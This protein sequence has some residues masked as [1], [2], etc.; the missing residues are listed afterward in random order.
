MKVK[1][2]LPAS[3]L[4][5]FLSIPTL[6]FGQYFERNKVQYRTFDFFVK[7]TDH[8][9]VHH[10]PR[11]AEAALDSALMLERWYERHAE[12]L[13][14]GLEDRQK[15]ILYNNFVDFEQT[16]A[17]S[18][19]IPPEEGGITESLDRRIIVPLT[20]I[21]AENFHVLGHELVHAF[22]ME[23][24]TAPSETGA[25]LQRQ[26]TWFVEGQAEYLSLGPDDPLTS[27]WMRDAV[28]NVNIPSIDDLSWRPD[29]FFPYRFGHAVWAWIDRTWGKEGVRSFFGAAMSKGIATAVDS[30]LHEK[31]LDEFSRKWK[32]DLLKTT[33]PQLAG[34]TLP[35]NAGRTLPGIGRGTNLSPV[36]SPDGEYIA[37]FSRRDTF[38]FALYLA[39]A[40]N[41]RV[42][43]TLAGSENDA[44][45]DALRFIDSAGTWSPDSRSFA[46]TVEKDGSDAVA[47]ADVPGGVVRKVLR[48]KDVAGVS[49]LAWSPDGGHIALSGTRDGIRDLYLLDPDTGSLEQLTD[50]WHAEIQPA[51]SPNSRTLAFAVDRGAKTDKAGLSFGSMNIGFMDMATRQ[52]RIVSLKDG[53]KHINP[54]F[55]PDG[56]ALYFVSDP[57][58]F[59]D[60][61]RYDLDSEEFLRVT[62][63]A[64]G[65]SGL[66]RLSPCLSVTRSTGELVFLLFSRGSYEVHALSAEQSRGIPVAFEG[67]I[68]AQALAGEG[69]GAGGGSGGGPG[70][71][72]VG[73]GGGGGSGGGCG[74][75]NHG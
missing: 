33:M 50:D 1:E 40:A 19:L 5:F 11:S 31:S 18:G 48:L 30:A 59:S 26:P 22:Q 39:D 64:T 16:N 32:D 7:K 43:K 61:Y 14:F 75:S 53:A 52:I 57:D 34:R 66:T 65:V 12:A 3:I 63:V 17:V 21:Y 51:W 2:I 70:R 72:G 13:G 8:F 9:L 24:R 41:G 56:R 20:G 35:E 27:M 49:N 23:P 28:L 37:V 58:G 6:S 69:G 36:V 55:S 46:F 62:N 38:N 68:P 60:I 45:F 25:Q 10:Y 42:F 15:V 74:G 54:Q 29:E 67:G 47:V 71:G 73:G 44:S 4:L